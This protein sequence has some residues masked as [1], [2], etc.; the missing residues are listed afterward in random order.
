VLPCNALAAFAVATLAYPSPSVRAH[1]GEVAA[2][3]SPSS[4]MVLVAR[5]TFVMGSHPVELQLVMEA[6]KREPRGSQC[7]MRFFANELAQHQVTVSSYWLDRTEVTVGA[8]G[9]C[10]EAAACEPPPYE[11]GASRFD[12][13]TLPVT[14]VT[15]T[16]AQAYCRWAGKRLPTEAEWERAARGR[17]SRRFP[18]GE[19]YATR[20][21]NHGRF[22]PDATDSSDG[23]EELSPVGSFP[24]GRTPDGFDDLAGNVAEW[25][26]DAYEDSYEAM[27]VTD[28]RGPAFG[29]HK[30]VRGGSYQDGMVWLRGASRSYRLPSARETSLGFRCAKD[31]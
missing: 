1:T 12:R 29:A 26:S 7:D 18:W 10:V 27:P 16:D 2:L 15:F 6:C 20:R 28:P 8:Y 30:V 3:R 22:A 5:S 13:P 11:Q 25:T 17:T 31:A 9:R 4:E 19:H 21:A 14:L 23:F 24:D